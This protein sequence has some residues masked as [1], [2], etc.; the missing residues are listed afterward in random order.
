MEILTLLKANIRHK[1][2][3]FV[4]IIL[5]MI[6]I[7]MSMTAILSVQDNCTAGIENALEQ[8]DAGDMTVYIKSEALTD[9][10]LNSVKNHDIVERVKTNKAIKS[11][12]AEANGKTDSN[13]WF[14]RELRDEYK[15]FNGYMSA[16]EEKT[17]ALKRGEIY[18]PQGV[19]TKLGCNVGEPLLAGNIIL[20]S[21]EL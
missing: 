2:G 10:L 17:P 13:S 8:V 18:V 21:K 12:R 9:K 6:I 15:I 3:T 7:S 11:D 20:K 4:S 16:Y 5:L 19:M 1:K 14:L